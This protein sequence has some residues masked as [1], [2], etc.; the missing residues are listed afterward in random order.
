LLFLPVAAWLWALNAPGQRFLPLLARLLTQPAVQAGPFSFFS[1][2]S[3]A[4]GTFG[5]RD[6]ALRLQL[7]RSRYG[8]GYL[9]V[10]LRTA[11]PP[12]L[13]GAAVEACTQDEA[14]RRALVTLA[15]H[16]LVLD[17]ENGWLKALWNPQGLVIFPGPF[18]EPK[19]REVL[20]ALQS[21]AA[22]LDA[23]AEES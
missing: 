3:Y 11:G 2:R 1:G 8:Q 17:V 18:S 10:A 14:G 6:V 9:V 21:V 4:S 22:S 5:G 13:D 15:T 7:K 23:A 20:G 16:D 12:T 19:W